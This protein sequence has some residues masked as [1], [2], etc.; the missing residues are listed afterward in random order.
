MNMLPVDIGGTHM[1]ILVTG[2]KE[3]CE[4]ESGPKITPKLM[5]AGVK[6]PGIGVMTWCLW[7]IQGRSHKIDR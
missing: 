4:F 5:V 3:R 7:G 6:R 2:Q 1:K